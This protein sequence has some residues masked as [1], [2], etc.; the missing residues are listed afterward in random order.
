MKKYWIIL[1]ISVSLFVVFLILFFAINIGKIEPNKEIL[2]TLSTSKL[3]VKRIINV[4]NK[5][6]FIFNSFSNNSAKSL[7]STSLNDLIM[8]IRDLDKYIIDVSILSL[9]NNIISSVP[10]YYDLSSLSNKDLNA[11]GL[12]INQNNLMLIKKIHSSNGKSVAKIVVIFDKR[13]FNLAANN[14]SLLKVDDIFILYNKNKIEVSKILE[15]NIGEISNIMLPENKIAMHKLNNDI[16][17][18]LTKIEESFLIGYV[19]KYE[20]KTIA[21]FFTVMLLANGLLILLSV[22]LL[23]LKL[24]I[25]KKSDKLNSKNVELNQKIETCI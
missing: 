8:E 25:A 6:S 20:I 12:K 5:Y 15:K 22:G 19:E 11:Y 18:Y 17:L 16:M 7:I 4:A 3:K 13:F 10:G 14:L 24:H 2:S 9:D 23:I 21:E 1:S